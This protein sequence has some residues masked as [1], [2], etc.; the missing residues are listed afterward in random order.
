MM[1]RLYSTFAHGPPGVGLL[2]MRLVAGGILIL[3]G[4]QSLMAGRGVESDV[5]QAAMI[6]LGGLLVLGLWT[7]FVGALVGVGALWDAHA[8]DLPARWILVAAV[9]VALALTGP[10]AWSLDAYLFG[11]RRLEIRDRKGPP[12]PP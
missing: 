6:G 9:G 4:T 2:V 7:P 3:Y 8:T 5:S 11:W 12:P 10:G 1:R